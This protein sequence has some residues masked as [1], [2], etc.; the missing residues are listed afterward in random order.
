M[1]GF[2]GARIDVDGD[3]IPDM[4]VGPFGQVRPDVGTFVKGPPLYGYGG[5]GYGMPYGGARIDVDGDG[6]PDMRVGP[7]GQV[8]P[9]VGTFVKGPPLYG[10]AYYPPPYY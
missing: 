5:Y 6:I 9:D 10:A 7:F 8:R 1:F 4:R 3:G 2:G